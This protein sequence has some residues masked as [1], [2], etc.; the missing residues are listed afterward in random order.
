MNPIILVVAGIVLFVLGL[1]LGYWIAH[2]R[3][4]REAVK[5]SDIQSEMDDYRRRVSEHFGETAQHFQAIGQQYRSL[6][7]HMA[8]GAGA[9]CDTTQSEALLGF[10]DS[11]AA[12][13][14]TSAGDE[15]QAPPEVIKDYAD[16]EEIE[17]PT[18][19]PAAEAAD[20]SA[21]LAS[22]PAANDMTAEPPKE[23]VVAE[24]VDTPPPAEEE[25]TVH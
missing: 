7:K 16:A 15:P 3:G 21:S 14:T 9:L 11:D 20:E 2:F 8:Q 18:A 17:S 6:Y 24:Q 13:A 1:G 12:A 22:S 4:K 5:A 19:E 25:R 23:E 10:A